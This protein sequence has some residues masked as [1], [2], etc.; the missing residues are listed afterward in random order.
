MCLYSN[1]D[2]QNIF[3]Q[4]AANNGYI[5]EIKEGTLGCGLTI[6]HGTGLKT[7]IIKE[8]RLNEWSSAHKVRFYN[9]MPKKYQD[10]LNK[11]N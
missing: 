9:K 4:Y 2:V 1:T 11:I 6:C 5:T 7:C 8:V 3:S 10:I